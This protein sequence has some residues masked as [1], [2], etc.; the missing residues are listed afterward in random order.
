MHIG[1]IGGGPAGY[2][3]AIR[4]AQLGA[5]VTVVEKEALGGVCTNHGCI[6]TKTLY[7][8]AK[9][10]HDF[11]WG[12]SKKL[13]SGEIAHD[14][15]KVIDFKNSVVMRLVRGIEFLFKNRTSWNGG[16]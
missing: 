4:A 3:A 15:H 5:R 16:S 14:W 12:L 9:K 13:W 11:H 10:M 7:L 6:P 1:I 2:V 8:A